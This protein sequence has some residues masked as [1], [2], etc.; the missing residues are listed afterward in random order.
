MTLNESREVWRYIM[1]FIYLLAGAMHLI[2]PQAFLPIMPAWVPQPLQVILFTGLCE[3]FGAV[4]LLVPGLR[5]FSGV[6]L[7]LYAVCVFPANIKHAL[8]DLPIIDMHTS[9]WYHAP[10]LLLQPVLVWMALYCSGVITWPRQ[11]VDD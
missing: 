6:M 5:R 9:W 3:L 1:A 4:G 10:R 11:V 8:D 2:V 7:A